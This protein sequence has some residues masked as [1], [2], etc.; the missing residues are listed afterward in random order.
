[1]SDD[2]GPVQVARHG[3]V[4]EKFP[5]RTSVAIGFGS[6]AQDSGVTRLDLNDMLIKNAQ[7]TFV[8]RVAGGAM[9]EVGIDDGDLVLVDRAIGA[10]HGHTVIAVVGDEFVCRRLWREGRELRLRAADG[11]VADIVAGE[12]VEVDVWGVVTCVIKPLPV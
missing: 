5:P 3:G 1:M 2:V 7:A 11:E 9:R 12:G 4:G 10:S 8:M 6:P